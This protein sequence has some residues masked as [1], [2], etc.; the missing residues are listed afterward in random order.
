MTPREPLA[1]IG[2]TLGIARPVA[3]ALIATIALGCGA[4]AAAIGLMAASAWLLSRAAEHPPEA[5]LTIGIVLVQVFGLSRGPFRYGERLVGHNAAF[6]LLA[7]VRVRLYGHLERLAPAGLPAFRSGDLMARLVSDVDALSDIVVR[8]L[9]AF[10]V[11]GLVGAATILAVWA[12]LPAAALVFAAALFLSAIP[13]PWLTGILARRR[14]SSQAMLRGE[15][16]ASVVDLVEGAPELAVYGAMEAQLDRI[17]SIDQALAAV[18]RSSAATTGIGLGLTTFLAG[19]A[20]WGVLV[21][22]VPAV[23]SGRLGGVWLG[24]LALVPLAAFELVS[25]LPAA[26]QALHRVRAS[27]ARAVRDRRHTGRDLRALLAGAVTGPPGRP[28]GPF[29]QGRLSGLV[30][31]R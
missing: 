31:S 1:P 10:A 15:L 30:S 21:V 16:A 11:A 20:T 17:D 28:R 12:F 3:S 7:S 23:D 25:A 18:A 4:V 9:P 22:G 27:A 2:R 26:S 5:A 24:S 19:A 29:T 8:I 6:R 13:V 14:E